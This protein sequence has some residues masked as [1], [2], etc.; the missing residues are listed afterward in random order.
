MKK[1]FSTIALASFAGL[2]AGQQVSFTAASAGSVQAGCALPNPI[3]V[4]ACWECFQ[5]L[6]DD[7]DDDNPNDDRR[8]ACY[9][10]A[11][12]FFT[13]CLGRVPAATPNSPRRTGLNPDLNLHESF[14]I[15]GD[16]QY[17]MFVPAGTEAD[18]IAVFI[19]YF[20]GNESRQVRL[21]ETEFFVFDQT[22]VEDFFFFIVI[23][24]N[25]DVSASSSVGVI[26]GIESDSGTIDYAFA[27]S[28]D[29][30]DSFDI[31]G[32]GVFDNFD[33]IEAMTQFSRGEL[34]HAALTRILHA[35]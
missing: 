27:L 23:D 3:T 32:D 10:G 29:V 21:D 7:C 9:D 20:D 2:S 1:L 24:T 11:N 13:W 15:R 31:N 8:Q 14:D 6:L 28:A 26:T 5:D 16:M 19:R 4:A 17:E 12:N 33:R 35:D 22:G 30:I 25:L 18:D 34:D